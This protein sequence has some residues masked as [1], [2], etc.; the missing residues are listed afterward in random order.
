MPLAYFDSLLSP[1]TLLIL[2]VIAVLLYGE[3]LPEVARSFGKQFA[4]FK[5]SMNQIRQDFESAARDLTSSID[6]TV[7]PKPRITRARRL[8]G[9][10]LR[11]PAKNQLRRSLSRRLRWSRCRKLIEGDHCGIRYQREQELRERELVNLSVLRCGS[12]DM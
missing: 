3:R 12:Q 9:W 8:R 1:S 4:Q 10:T 5:R 11:H 2:A 6:H 7:P